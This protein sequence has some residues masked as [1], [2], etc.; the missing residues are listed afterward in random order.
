MPDYGQGFEERIIPLTQSEIARQAG[1]NGSATQARL[2]KERQSRVLA[3][4]HAGI[5]AEEIAKQLGVSERTIWRDLRANADVL[6]DV[7][8]VIESLNLDSDDALRALSLTHDA[9]IRDIMSPDGTL[10]HPSAWPS[11]WRQGI[12]GD[13]K[14]EP[15]MVRSTDG[16]NASW[17]QQGHKVTVT[18]K[19]AD[20]IK[21]LE[22][23]M[24][25][26]AVDALAA[27]KQ[28]VTHDIGE[29]VAETLRGALTRAA[30]VRAEVGEVTP[31]DVVKAL[32]NNS[33]GT[34]IEVHP[35]E[36][37]E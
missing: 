21:V 17:E 6:R 16:E 31:Q 25:H 1:A 19:A 28:D 33:D 2:A 11:I 26:K 15:N 10:K 4:H 30:S 34:V 3:L 5:G 24:R 14:I 32:P 37:T 20:R 36:S 23:A 12:A 18:V 13:V 27:V 9:D 22:L 8:A 29:R 7:T 35:V